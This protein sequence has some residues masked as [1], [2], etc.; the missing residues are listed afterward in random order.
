MNKIKRLLLARFIPHRTAI[1]LGLLL[2]TG[3][4]QTILGSDL[5]TAAAGPGALCAGANKVLSVLAPW[6]VIMGVSDR[7]RKD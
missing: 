4:A 6:L 1:G 3:A 5:C 2:V 7:D